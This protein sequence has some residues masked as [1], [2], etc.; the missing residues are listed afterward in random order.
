MTLVEVTLQQ[1]D[2]I[3]HLGGGVDGVFRERLHIAPTMGVAQKSAQDADISET[4][5]F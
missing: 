3:Q 5:Y 1:M 4:G 2:L